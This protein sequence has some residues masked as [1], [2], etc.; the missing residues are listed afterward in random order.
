MIAITILT[1]LATSLVPSSFQDY[2]QI[3]SRGG[4]D[5]F[6]AKYDNNSDLL[7]IKGLGGSGNEFTNGGIS[8]SDD[9]YVFIT[10]GFQSSFYYTETDFIVSEGL[11]DVFLAKFAFD[12]TNVWCRN[13]GSGAGH[14][15]P[16]CLEIDLDGDLLLG[17]YFKDSIQ[18]SIDLTT[19][20]DNTFKDYF[21]AKLEP[22]N[23]LAQWCKS[24]K[25]ID[26]NYSGF[27]FSITSTNENYYISGVFAD[28]VQIENDTIVSQTTNLYD[29]HIM[30][31]D[32]QGNLKWLRFI[33]GANHDY[34]Y[35]SSVD[36]DENIYVTG[37]FNSPQMIVDSTE[38]ESIVVDRI[39][40]DYD[41]YIV[42]YDSLGT[43]DWIRVN[44]GEGK[45]MIAL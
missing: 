8:I 44:G 39:G 26:T 9:E 28:S 5:L 42:K 7:W 24:L 11:D 38:N 20:A 33:Q 31:S 27:I 10:G 4:M 3:D 15:R 41:F 36:A 17:G 19:Y 29:T 6:L 43:L 12:G 16:T 18:L 1:Y 2:E 14:Q 45:W 25:S 34:S 37:Y 13:I 23:G 21:I 32:K 40:E 22:N 30:K 35:T